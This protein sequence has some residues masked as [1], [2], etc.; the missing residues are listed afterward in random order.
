MRRLMTSVLATL[1]LSVG[2][3]GA[4]GTQPPAADPGPPS[5]QRQLL[6][7]RVRARVEEIMRQRLELTDEQARRM[8]DLWMRLEPD[9]RSLNRDERETRAALRAE[10]MAGSQGNE[11]RIRELMDRIATLDRRKLE[12]REREQKELSSFLTATQRARF[13]ALQDEL[14]RAVTE[15]QRRRMREGVLGGR[16]RDPFDD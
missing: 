15:A 13:F 10:L 3:V 14:R 9:R 2:T 16:L 5:A 12:L 7:A 8:S 1:V 4:Q 6:E 11:T